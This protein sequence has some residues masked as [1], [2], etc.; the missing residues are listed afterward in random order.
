MFTSSGRLESIA[1]LSQQRAVQQ[2]Y[3]LELA[4][5]KT[6]KMMITSM[7]THPILSVISK[8]EN[9]VETLSCVTVPRLAAL[10]PFSHG[11]KDDTALLGM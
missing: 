7:P 6:A 8:R 2:N 5:N 10:H 11:Q 4:E 9:L 3:R 1:F